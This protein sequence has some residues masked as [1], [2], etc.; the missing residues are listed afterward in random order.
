MNP[1]DLVGDL[2]PRELARTQDP[3]LCLRSS[4]AILSANRLEQ[5]RSSQTT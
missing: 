2:P 1:S 5:F 3:S 4:I